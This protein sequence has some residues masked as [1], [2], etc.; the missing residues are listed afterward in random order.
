LS[1]DIESVQ[2]DTHLPRQ[3]QNIGSTA[4]VGF[5]YYKYFG[6]K[7]GKIVVKPEKFLYNT[8]IPGRG[9]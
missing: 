7:F 9:I 2:E 8:N 6:E 1:E 4:Y 3:V 5:F